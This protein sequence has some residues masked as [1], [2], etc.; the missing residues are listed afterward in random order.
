MPPAAFRFRHGRHPAAG[1]RRGIRQTCVLAG[2]ARWQ[3]CPDVTERRPQRPDLDWP[4]GTAG[5]IWLLATQEFLKAKALPLDAI[6]DIS[7]GAA[8]IHSAI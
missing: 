1:D 8:S 2:G 7:Y 4:P 6:R 3:P 5:D